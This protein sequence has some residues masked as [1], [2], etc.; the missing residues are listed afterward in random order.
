MKMNVEVREAQLANLPAVLQL[1]ELVHLPTEG[2]KEH[3]TYFLVGLDTSANSHTNA[4]VI[5]C[6]G[7]EMYL[8]SA[9]LRSLAVHPAFQGRGI[10]KKMVQAVSAW[11][12]KLEVQ[13]LF[14]LT[15]T[16]V[17]F[18]QN[19]GFNN[20]NREQVPKN[21]QQSIEFTK[22]CPTAPCLTKKI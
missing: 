9:L 3:F 15:D 12:R 13:H 8:P 19:L 20:I 2:V 14:L 11:A 6:V 17:D 16:A 4:Q 7:L 1:L 22:L 5:S 18:F 21:V 10:G